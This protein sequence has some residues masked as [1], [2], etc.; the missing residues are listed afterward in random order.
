MVFIDSYECLLLAEYKWRPRGMYLGGPTGMNLES[1]EDL[2]G[3]K[4]LLI[5]KR[6]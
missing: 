4:V 2:I 6:F 5:A 1:L 3:L